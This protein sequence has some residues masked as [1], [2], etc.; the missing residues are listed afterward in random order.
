[1][2]KWIFE[3][4]FARTHA[5]YTTLNAGKLLIAKE[6]LRNAGIAKFKVSNGNNSDIRFAASGGTPHTIKVFT[7]D[8]ERAKEV[9]Q[10]IK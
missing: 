6:C 4:F 8:F 10:E 5:V 2:F 3:T 7:K 1:M 9:L